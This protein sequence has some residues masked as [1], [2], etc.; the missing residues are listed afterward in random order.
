MMY[1]IPFVLVLIMYFI[2]K[3]NT[4]GLLFHKNAALKINYR[5]QDHPGQY[6]G[7]LKNRYGTLV[8][9][10]LRKN[11]ELRAIVIR[12]VK[13]YHSGVSVNLNQSAIIAFVENRNQGLDISVRFRITSDQQVVDLKDCK[14]MLSG[15]LNLKDGTR[16]PFKFSIPIQN[17]Y[18]Y[19]EELDIQ[20]FD[21]PIFH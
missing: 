15:V 10:A 2:Y 8:F 3:R 20:K 19:Q 16:L 17:V 6:S 1:F 7:D 9:S 14:V 11:E 4:A 12:K 21:I 5:F 18:Q 13:I